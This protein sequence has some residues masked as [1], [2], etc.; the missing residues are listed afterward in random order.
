MDSG[1]ANQG[2]QPTY[3]VA[4]TIREGE[5]TSDKNLPPVLEK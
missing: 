1:I 5:A 2:Y 3:E 4:R